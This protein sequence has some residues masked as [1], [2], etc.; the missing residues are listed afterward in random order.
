MTDAIQ[1][2]W[3]QKNVHTL[4]KSQSLMVV[5]ILVSFILTCMVFYCLNSHSSIFL[6]IV[7]NVLNLVFFGLLIIYIIK[8]IIK[9]KEVENL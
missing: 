2:N 9:A 5:V 8:K 4:D 6:I 7:M 1:I 3:Y